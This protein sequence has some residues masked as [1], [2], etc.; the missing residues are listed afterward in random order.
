MCIVVNIR[1]A[2][3]GWAATI[4]FHPEVRAQF[5]DF[6]AREDTFSLGVC[7]GCQLMGLLG[8]VAPDENTQGTVWCLCPGEKTFCSV[9]IH[10]NM[11]SCI[12]IDMLWMQVHESLMI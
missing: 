6:Y 1:V 2:C 5:D 7:N 11:I 9:L 3:L 8:W 12:V 4:M 10:S